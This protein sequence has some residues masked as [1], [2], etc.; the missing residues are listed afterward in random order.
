MIQTDTAITDKTKQ[1]KKLP[2][3]K[4]GALV[5]KALYS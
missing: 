2:I 1:D 4:S 5:F 3:E